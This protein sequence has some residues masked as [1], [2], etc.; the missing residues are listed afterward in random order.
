MAKSLEQ[1][2][3]AVSARAAETAARLEKATARRGKRI[4]G[5]GDGDGI[6]NEG[7]NKKPGG[8]GVTAGGGKTPDLSPS[9]KGAKA[10]ALLRMTDPAKIT[11][12]NR[13]KTLKE[14]V[15]PNMHNNQ[16]KN[17]PLRYSVALKHFE[18]AVDAQIKRLSKK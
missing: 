12:L 14:G 2:I 15:I 4:P 3:A 7:R 10:A 17:T 16:A 1:R 9:E 11:D 6:P 13:L 18:E 8:K 5:D